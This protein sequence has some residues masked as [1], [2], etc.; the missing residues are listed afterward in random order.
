MIDSKQLLREIK[1]NIRILD[2]CKRHDF[3]IPLDRHAKQPMAEP[4]FGC[5]WR[6]A[7]CGGHVGGTERIWYNRGL[8]HAK[9]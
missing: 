6:C 4:T 5:Y 2:S 1:E 8:E 3:S 9:L 7:K